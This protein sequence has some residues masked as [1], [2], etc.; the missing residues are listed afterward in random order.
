MTYR[1]QK[2]VKFTLSTLIDA[3]QVW[4]V[5][6][7]SVES[8][9]GPLSAIPSVLPLRRHWDTASHTSVRRNLIWNLRVHKRWS[10][11]HMLREFPN[12]ICGNVELLITSLRKLTQRVHQRERRVA[13]DQNQ[14]EPTQT[15]RWW[16][17]SSVV[18]KISRTV[19]RVPV[20]SKDKLAYLVHVVCCC[21]LGH[22]VG[23]INLNPNTDPEPDPIPYPQY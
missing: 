1:C 15:L 5:H 2:L 7:C 4:Y 18:R 8:A 13:G 10:S 20:K 3:R 6:T 16:V 21:C 12:K 19:T 17:S 22:P 23:A 9:Y 11:R 14:P